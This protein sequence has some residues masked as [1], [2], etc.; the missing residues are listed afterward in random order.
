MTEQEFL[1]WLNQNNT[2]DDN[3]CWIWNGGVNSAGYGCVGKD[4]KMFLVHRISLEK[5]IGRYLDTKEDARHICPNVPNTR[6]YNPEHLEVG[7]HKQNMQDMVLYGRSQ[8]GSKNYHSKLTE[9][10]VITIRAIR[11]MFLLSELAEIFD[12]DQALISMIVNRKIWKHV[13]A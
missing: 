3:N 11:S 5:K 6:C 8:T 9:D 10:N 12:V 1:V 7:T 4:N 13:Q 2:K